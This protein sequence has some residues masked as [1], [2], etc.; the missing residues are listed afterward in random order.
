MKL[1]C[2]V[3]FQSRCFHFGKI[4]AVAGFVTKAPHKHAGVISVPKNHALHSVYNGIRP[5]RIT[6]RHAFAPHA[7]ALHFAF[8]HYIEAVFIAH[9]VK[10]RIVGVMRSTYG[11]DII[12]FHNIQILRVPLTGNSPAVIRIKVMAVYTPD[13]ERH[14]VK[15]DLFPFDLHLLET[16]FVS[17]YGINVFIYAQNNDKRIKTRRFGRPFLWIFHFRFHRKIRCGMAEFLR[18]LADL[19]LPARIGNQIRFAGGAA[20]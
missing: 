13:H 9:F 16:D 3:Q 19:N 4:I 12:L 18:F 1:P 14:A 11:I 6:A 5:H 8:I 17:F 15:I 10:I 2:I 7:M 20:V